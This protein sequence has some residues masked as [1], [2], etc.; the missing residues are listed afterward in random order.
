MTQEKLPHRKELCL[1]SVSGA[2]APDF[3]VLAILN[4]FVESIA[5]GT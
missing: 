2:K 3:T 5:I 1:Q 4:F